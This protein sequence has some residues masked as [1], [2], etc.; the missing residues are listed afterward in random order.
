MRYVLAPYYRR[1]TRSA[2]RTRHSRLLTTWCDYDPAHGRVM[3]EAGVD[4]QPFGQ[5]C[6][7]H[8][9]A[10]LSDAAKA[11]SVTLKQGTR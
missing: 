5:S 11:G 1:A 3:W 4:G 9:G 8:L 7:R 6:F 2:V 10:L